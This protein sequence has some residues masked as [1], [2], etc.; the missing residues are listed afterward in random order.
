MERRLGEAI[1]LD[2]DPANPSPVPPS[3]ALA[4]LGAG[5]LVRRSPSLAGNARVPIR[6][7]RMTFWDRPA[8]ALAD[9]S[10]LG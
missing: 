5:A 1:Y 10:V 2:A 7:R 4:A 3:G 6:D 8:P 9:R